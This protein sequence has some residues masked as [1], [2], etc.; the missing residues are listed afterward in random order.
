MGVGDRE[1]HSPKE[2]GPSLPRKKKNHHHHLPF[3]S[4]LPLSFSFPPPAPL[5]PLFFCS[6][7]TFRLCGERGEG[8]RAPL[9]GGGRMCRP[10]SRVMDVAR[11]YCAALCFFFV[12]RLCHSHT[13][14]AASFPFSLLSPP[15]PAN[16]A[17]PPAHVRPPSGAQSSPAWV[18]R[19]QVGEEPREKERERE[20]RG[21]LELTLRRRAWPRGEGSRPHTRPP[22]NL[23]NAPPPP[24]A[25]STP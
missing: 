14:A 9:A 12:S 5:W 11:T 23:F 19:V 25:R 8:V 13:L 4:P 7:L 24:P 21:A 18:G 20:A 16:N 17:Q 1:E 2:S 22:S 15:P 10:P 3:S 6:F